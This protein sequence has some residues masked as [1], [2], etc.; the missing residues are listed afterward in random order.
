MLSK[1]DESD[2]LWGCGMVA[3]IAPP[4]LTGTSLSVPFVLAHVVGFGSVEYVYFCLRFSWKRWAGEGSVRR[5][6]GV[7]APP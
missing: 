2:T 1:N 5:G 3:G 4:R 7:V 6:L